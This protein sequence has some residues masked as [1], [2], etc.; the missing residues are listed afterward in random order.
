MR[1]LAPSLRFIL[2]GLA[3]SLA[4]SALMLLKRQFGLLPGFEPYVALQALLQDALGPNLPAWSALAASYLNGSIVIGFVFSRVYARLPGRSGAA[5]GALFGL[6]IWVLMG[7]VAFPALGLGPYGLH[8]GEPA[9]P[10]FSLLMLLVYGLAMGL[11]HARLTQRA[12][13]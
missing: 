5:K 9:A 7:A 4:H 8:T 3:G 12:K 1:R 10:L 6:A 13:G 2:A 11:A